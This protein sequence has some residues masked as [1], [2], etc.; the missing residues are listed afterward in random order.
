LL[1]N[2]QPK[3]DNKKTGFL[4]AARDFSLGS[5]GTEGELSAELVNRNILAALRP[6]P[7]SSA[8]HLRSAG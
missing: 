6:N 8:G 3:P 1:V 4:N 7:P 5:R 2:Y